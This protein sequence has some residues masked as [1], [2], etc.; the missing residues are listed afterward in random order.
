MPRLNCDFLS[1]PTCPLRIL[2]TQAGFTFMGDMVAERHSAWFLHIPAGRDIA[3]P[4]LQV[5]VNQFGDVIKRH[6]FASLNDKRGVMN[7]H[8]LRKIGIV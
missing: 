2:L 5:S 7:R 6:Q 3:F 4:I 8:A 1:E